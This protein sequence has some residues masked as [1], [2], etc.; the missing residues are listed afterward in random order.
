MSFTLT[1]F[2]VFDKPFDFLHFGQAVPGFLPAG[3]DVF[4]QVF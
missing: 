3:I 2:K 1:G 4:L